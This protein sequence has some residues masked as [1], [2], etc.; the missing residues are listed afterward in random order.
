MYVTVDADGSFYCGES[1]D[2]HGRIVDHRRGP[3]GR[4][5]GEEF[6]FVPVVGGKSLARHIETRTIEALLRRGFP[7][8]PVRGDANHRNF[9]LKF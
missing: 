7:V 6:A 3:R 4:R 8:R 2:L 9:N 5:R 1:D